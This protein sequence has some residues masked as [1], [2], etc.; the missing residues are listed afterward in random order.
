[1]F[2]FKPLVIFGQSMPGLL[3]PL[4]DGIG[5]YIILLCELVGRDVLLQH[6]P[7]D[8]LLLGLRHGVRTDHRSDKGRLDTSQ[9]YIRGENGNM[10]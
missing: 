8:G 2:L 5:A 4:S 9:R 7:H 1:M 6:L 3:N 10:A